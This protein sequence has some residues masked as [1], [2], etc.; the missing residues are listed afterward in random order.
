LAIDDVP[1]DAATDA[2][3]AY[4]R[5]PRNHYDQFIAPFFLESPELLHAAG[6]AAKPDAVR[7]TFRLRDGAPSVA[8]VG[9]EPPDPDAPRVYS[10]AY[11]SPDPI[12]HEPPDWTPLLARDALLPVALQEY[13]DPFRSR[14]WPGDRTYYFQL[15]SNGDEPGHS[16]G[17]FV[18]Q[19]EREVAERAPRAIVVDLRFD[20]GGN[21]V[22]TASLMKRLPRLS[23]AVSHVYALTSA[24]TFS[25]GIVDLALLETHGGARLTVL[26]E[27]PGDRTRLWAEGG[28]LTLPNAGLAI[29]FA[30]GLHDYERGCRGESGC[31]WTLYLYPTHVASLA[32]DVPVPYTFDDYT[33]LRD[34]VLDRALALARAL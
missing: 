13:A 29:G 5:G 21:F 6:I 25:A 3:F 14:Y 15:K 17:A 26:G 10:D 22:L 34:P 20:Q 32:P 31:F 7:L 1:I 2:L 4:A 33:G 11:L 19:V 9:A 8:T 30:T 23:P 24:W 27:A 28:A 18:A 16:L 12:E